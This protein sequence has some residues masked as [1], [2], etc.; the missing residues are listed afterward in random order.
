MFQPENAQLL[1]SNLNEEEIFIDRNGEVFPVIL[2]FYRNGTIVI[3]PTLSREQVEQELDFF[4][5]GWPP[6]SSSS[7]SS[8]SSKKNK[9]PHHQSPR[10]SL[11]ATKSEGTDLYTELKKLADSFHN[12][13]QKKEQI[14]FNEVRQLFSSSLQLYPFSLFCFLFI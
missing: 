14:Q 13:L 4:Q 10:D 8:S 11:N 1:P 9:H 6:L 3:P 5:I 7:S 12:E 2:N